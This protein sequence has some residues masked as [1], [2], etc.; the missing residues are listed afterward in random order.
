[1]PPKSQRKN[2]AA[3]RSGEWTVAPR[4][5]LDLEDADRAREGGEA[6]GQPAGERMQEGER[7]SIE[8]RGRGAP[9][10]EQEEER[11][12]VEELREREARREQDE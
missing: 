10:Q 3:R 5:A 2:G 4:V 9:E 1:M 11:R 12:R 6:R 7:E 8:P